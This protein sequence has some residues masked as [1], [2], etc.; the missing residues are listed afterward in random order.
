V[1]QNIVHAE[2]QYSQG[3][4]SLPLFG[5]VIESVRFDGEWAEVRCKSCQVCGF[6]ENT[7]VV[8]YP[9]PVP[10]YAYSVPPEI[11]D[12]VSPFSQWVCYENTF[13]IDTDTVFVK[14]VGEEWLLY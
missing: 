10:E 8:P 4:C 13:L 14:K 1:I 5:V 12:G 9:I 11:P 6:C 2:H 7:W 3:I